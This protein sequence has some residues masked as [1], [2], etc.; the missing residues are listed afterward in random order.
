MYWKILYLLMERLYHEIEEIP[1]SYEHFPDN[2]L[3]K[4]GER[5]VGFGDMKFVPPS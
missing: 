3:E 4:S 5:Y 1:G 2:S